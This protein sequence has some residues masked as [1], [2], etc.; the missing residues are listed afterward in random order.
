MI[1][2]QLVYNDYDPIIIDYSLQ[3]RV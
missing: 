3:V 1:I 2:I